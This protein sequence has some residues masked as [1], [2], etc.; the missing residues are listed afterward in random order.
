M[1]LRLLA[2]EEKREL[3]DSLVEAYG[4]D[5]DALEECEV[6]EGEEGYWAVSPSSIPRM[7]MT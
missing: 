7:W 5:G 4:F 1:S 3:M 2:P 6:L